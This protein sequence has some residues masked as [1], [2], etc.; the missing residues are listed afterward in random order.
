M[1]GS[2]E[3]MR[4]PGPLGRRVQWWIK[5]VWEWVVAGLLL[6]LLSPFL[7]FL[8][9]L[10]KLDSAGP[11]L[12]LQDRLGRNG[13]VFRMYKF[14]SLRWEP[15][16]EPLL[17]ADGSTRVCPADV[18]LT[19]LGQFLRVGFDE[20]PQLWNVLRN[21]MALIGPRPDEPFHRN[22]YTGDEPRKLAVL[23]GITG[24][25]QSLGRNDIPWKERIRLDLHYIDHY[26]LWLDL[27][28]AIRTLAT[29][30]RSEGVYGDA[31]RR[32]I[33][34]ES[35]YEKI[36]GSKDRVVLVDKTD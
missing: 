5:R 32:P 28:I 2:D 30:F 8:A 29:L 19:R 9:V 6:V 22:L 23:P 10:I 33:W 1:N 17:N 36:S 35:R 34:P 15:G 7:G 18:R 11:V 12:F 21:E 4:T 20:L 13:R 25:P 24:L 27:K 31:G 3:C 14:R 16:R 26:S